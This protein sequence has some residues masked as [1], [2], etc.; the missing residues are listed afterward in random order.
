MTVS[1][2]INNFQSGGKERTIPAGKERKFKISERRGNDRVVYLVYGSY[3]QR[4]RMAA[5][6]SMQS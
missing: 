6:I 3:V 4:L 2:C 1:T 5:L